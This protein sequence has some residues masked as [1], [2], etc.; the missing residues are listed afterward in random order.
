MT[1]IN[2]ILLAGAAA[3]CAV[4]DTHFQQ[5]QISEDGWGAMHLLETVIGVNL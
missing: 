3:L 1:F 5:E 2:G 4:A